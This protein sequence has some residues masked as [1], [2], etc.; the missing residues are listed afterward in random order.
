M[1]DLLA[2]KTL[3]TLKRN[4]EA[5]T[6]FYSVHP[7]GAN[8]VSAGDDDGG[9]FVYDTR[10][11]EKPVFTAHDCEQ[12]ISDI[13]GRFD[14]RR[15]MV[16]TSGEGTLTA[17]DL[18]ANKMLEPQSELFDAGFQCVKLLE[19][20]KKVVIGGEDGAVYVFNQNEW[21]HTSGKFAISSDL[22]NRGKCSIDCLD[23]LPDNSTFVVGCSDG[24]M[25]SLTLWPHQVLGEA[26]VCR[27]SALESLHV[28]PNADKSQLV[29]CG[30][31]Y[32][33]F[34][35]FEE[36]V[37]KEDDED[38]DEDSGEDEESNDASKTTPTSS[39]ATTEGS[40]ESD[41]GESPPTDPKQKKL[42]LD[43]DEHLDIFK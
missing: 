23:I 10:T 38:D 31:N 7:F 22:S 5:R 30:E 8:L 19:A 29:V 20:N 25:R 6:Q 37:E 1:H 3:H 32:I 35:K 4:D 36:K 11:P 34:L 21:A 40:D 2:N 14:A 13:D 15:M 17:Y 28:N 26:V 9:I 24:R 16:C 42:K 27:K 39:A 43:L 41:A 18:R 12:Y 33:D